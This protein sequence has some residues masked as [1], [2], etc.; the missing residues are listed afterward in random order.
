MRSPQHQV[1]P[2][3]HMRVKA[4]IANDELSSNINKFSQVVFN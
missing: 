1:S 3:Q 4:I 2:H